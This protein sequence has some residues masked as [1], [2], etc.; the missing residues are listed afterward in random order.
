MIIGQTRKMCQEIF[1]K[2]LEHTNNFSTERGNT[3][4]CI[5]NRIQPYTESKG[6]M[7]G[8]IDNL[9]QNYMD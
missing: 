9:M 7:A 5:R 4:G 3:K 1:Y 2:T 8:R 6:E